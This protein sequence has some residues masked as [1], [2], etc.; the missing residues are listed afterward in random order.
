MPSKPPAPAPG[1]G[2]GAAWAADR[3]DHDRDRPSEVED[4][5]EVGHWEGDCIMG[6]GNRSAIGTLV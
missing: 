4:R 5:V 6:A 2:P 3:D 1:S